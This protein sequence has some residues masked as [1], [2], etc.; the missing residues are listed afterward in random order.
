MPRK[1]VYGPLIFG[2]IGAASGVV[3]A[4]LLHY[5][6]VGDRVDLEDSLP[7]AAEGAIIGILVGYVAMRLYDRFTG[8]RPWIE[9]VAVTLLFGS[10]AAVVG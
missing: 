3:A 8:V 4:M 7:L 10:S 6:P 9:T 2:V 1:L 5:D